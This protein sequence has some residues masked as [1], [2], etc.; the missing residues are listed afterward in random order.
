[1]TIGFIG[2]GIMGESMCGRLITAG[3]HKPIVYDAQRSLVEKL[4]P[5][6]A[7]GASSAAEVGRRSSHIIIMVPN[8]EHVTAV[9]DVER[10]PIL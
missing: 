4:T 1:M 6:D 8:S 3:R 5:M 2:L 10:R 7:E 9:V